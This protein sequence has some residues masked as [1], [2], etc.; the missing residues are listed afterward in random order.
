[1]HKGWRAVVHVVDNMGEGL[2]V[3]KWKIDYGVVGVGGKESWHA[4]IE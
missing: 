1:M 4:G 2:G 3:W